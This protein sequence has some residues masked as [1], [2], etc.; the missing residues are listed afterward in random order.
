MSST[1]I[2]V[3][4]FVLLFV[5]MLARVPIGFAMA[6][7]GVAG[8]W[9]LNGTWPA[10]NLLM[11]SPFA[12]MSDYSLSVIPLFILMGV[13][14]SRGGMSQELFRAGKAW[15]G[16]LP[17]G[18]AVS[19]IAA[20]GGFAAI[21]GSSVATAATMSTVALPEM[22]KQG[23]APGLAA[24]TIAVGGTLG[25]MI[26]PSGAMLI[27]AILTEQDVGQLFA[28][29]ILPGLL[30]MLMYVVVIAIIAR[31][32]PALFPQGNRASWSERFASLR[33]IWAVFALFG[34]VVATLYGGFVTVTEAASVGCL[35]ALLIG[36]LRKRLSA[37]DTLAC[38][39]EAL[40][41]SSA[42]FVVAIGSFI[43]GYFLTV[44]QAAQAMTDWLVH[45]P[46]GPYGVL[47]LI[48][49]AY[50]IMGALMDE[51]AMILLTVP[52]VF[53]AI[54]QL[55]FDPIWFGVI[56]VMVMTL[57]MVM[58]PVGINVFVINSIARD[59]PLTHIYRGV[60][61]FVLADLLRLALL[62]AFPVI[63]LALPQMIK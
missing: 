2:P 53:P 10:L 38:L 45:L 21:N 14:A 28:A 61:P 17:G 43:F 56:I 51:L 31:R 41:T 22:R 52:I 36:V 59:I 1:L 23:Y 48:L 19:T 30:G 62:V 11:N 25:I 34:L 24:G 40:R 27:Y 54:V 46:I 3:G 42:I 18:A 26:P 32:S 16:H 39:I 63:S 5:L 57:G 58:P 8:F 4:G 50:I 35:G 44:T 55:G 49:V 33:G 9:V 47:T 6:I 29:G 37:A 12:T 60:M 15:L 7:A 13:F 20:C